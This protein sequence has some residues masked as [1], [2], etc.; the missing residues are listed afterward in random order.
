MVKHGLVKSERLSQT[1][2]LLRA[3]KNAFAISY[4]DL[5]LM[6]V[7]DDNI[8]LGRSSE[9]SRANETLASTPHAHKNLASFILEA[10]R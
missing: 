7:N 8:N 4:A 1:A 10:A 5:E 3:M 6:L 2:V 9:S